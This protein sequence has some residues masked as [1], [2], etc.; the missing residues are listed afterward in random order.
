MELVFIVVNGHVQL[1]IVKTGKRVGDEVE[2]V[3]GVDTGEQ[4]VTEGAV[5]LQDGQHVVLKP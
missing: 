1:R 4:V 3:S 5:N 2:L